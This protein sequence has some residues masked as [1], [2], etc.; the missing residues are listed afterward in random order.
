ML[1]GGAVVSFP[2]LLP[3]GRRFDSC[4]RYIFCASRD[5]WRTGLVSVRESERFCLKV[6]ADRHRTKSS[7]H[8][9]FECPTHELGCKLF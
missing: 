4:P 9:F 6:F 1:R 5:I 2:G 8:P 7:A 3:G